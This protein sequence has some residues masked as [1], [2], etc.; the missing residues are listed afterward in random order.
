MSIKHPG[1]GLT[2]FWRSYIYVVLFDAIKGRD[3]LSYFVLRELLI[4]GFYVVI[5]QL[6][7]ILALCV[8]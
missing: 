1:I 8:F 3:I 7:A 6:G 2:L 4:S 5:S